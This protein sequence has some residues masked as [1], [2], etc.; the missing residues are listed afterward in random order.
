MS[1]Y[2]DKEKGYWRLSLLNKILLILFLS[3]LLV[4]I[5]KVLM[6]CRYIRL[7][8]TI[9]DD[10]G[11][12]PDD[13]NWDNIPDTIPDY[14]DDELE[15]LPM[16]VSLERYFP[17]IGNQ[18][19]YGTCVAWAVGYNLNTA[20]NAIQNGWDEDD[21]KNVANQ[22]SPKDLWLGIAI[23]EKGNYCSG[24][25]FEPTFFVMKTSGAASMKEVP[26]KN[27]GSCKGKYTGDADNVISSYN[28]VL[29]KNGGLPSIKQLKSLLSDTIPLVISAHLGDKF[30]GWC[31]SDVISFDTHFGKDMQHAY[32]AM[33][34]TGYDDKI[35]AFRVR[36]S[37]GD[38]WGDEGS[39]WVDYD[40]F[41]DDFCDDVLMAKK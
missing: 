24:T 11:Y 37:W 1:T 14:E 16:T 19:Q 35:N 39:I 28:H 33:V 8:T 31:T 9:V 2:K 36:N 30:M 22:T 4:C 12:L 10:T 20:L 29:S 34:L 17:P 23:G 6:D 7:T 5:L 18:E 15:D 40:F 38:S 21:L 41:I 13:E 27:M 26:Y 25:T 32:H 3:L